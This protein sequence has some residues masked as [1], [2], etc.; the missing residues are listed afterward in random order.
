MPPTDQK[1]YTSGAERA[2]RKIAYALV[3]PALANTVFNMDEFAAII[4]RQTH[5]AEMLEA[6]RTVSTI[7]RTRGPEKWFPIEVRILVEDLIR[8]VEGR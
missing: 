7:V 4:S 8:K 5:D 2:A 3:Q 1:T 6:L